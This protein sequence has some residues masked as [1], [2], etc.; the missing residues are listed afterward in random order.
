M[1]ESTLSDLS[2]LRLARYDFTVRATEEMHLPRHKGALLRGGF[3]ITFKR[4]V[5]VHADLP[6]C[7]SCLLRTRCVYPAIFEASPPPDAQ[8]LRNHSSIPQPFVLVPPNDRRTHY[9]EGDPLR[10]GVLLIGQAVESLPY[11]IVTFQRLGEIGLGR[12][13]ARYTLDAVDFCDLPG[14]ERT[15]LLHN[16]LLQPETAARANNAAGVAAPAPDATPE[17][18]T[19]TF[20]TPTRLK[21]NGRFVQGAPPF[22]VLL[23]TLLRRVSSLSYFHGGQQWETDYRG[24]IERAQTVD[25]LQART[26]W[27]QYGRYSTR[28]RSY[29]PSG[30]IVGRATYG[31]DLGPFLPLLRLGEVLHV[32]KDTVFGSGRYALGG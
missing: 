16:G 25:I 20:H 27:V 10:F 18:I 4:S 23:R 2:H 13:R 15:P 31:G 29:I 11:F 8:V 1:I 14:G 26:H 9:A 5:C 32:G 24:W 30:G 6:P 12:D 17:R 28:K 21:H 7:G 3:G 19:V 22:H